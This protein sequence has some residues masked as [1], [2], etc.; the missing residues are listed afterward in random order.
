[1]SPSTLPNFESEARRL[2]YQAIGGACREYRIQHL[3]VAHHEDDQAETVL[4]RLVNGHKGMGLQGMKA[5]AEIP[6]CWGM[7][8]VSQSRA[9]NI[10]AKQKTGQRHMDSN[11]VENDYRLVGLESGGLT[12]HRPL[13]SFPK[14]RLKMT[15]RA[16][17]IQWVE[18]ETNHD[19][20]ITPRNAIRHLLASDRLPLALQKPSLLALAKTTQEKL[21]E[22][23]ARANS[24]FLNCDIIRF[25]LR[26]G[27]LLVRVPLG[28]ISTKHVPDKYRN[29][30]LIRCQYNAGLLLRKLT[31]LVSPRDIVSLQKLESVAKAIFPDLKDPCD[32]NGGSA[33][34][35]ANSSLPAS[36]TACGVQFRRLESTGAET[37]HTWSRLDP[38]YI[39]ELTRQPYPASI[40]L[41]TIYIPPTSLSPTH[42]APFHL[43]DGRYWIRVPNPTPNTHTLLI[44]PF[45]PSDLQPFQLSLPPARRT[46]LTNLLKMSAPG[47]V[48]WTLPAI[49]ILEEG[50]GLIEGRGRVIALPTLGLVAEG[51][52]GHVSWEI[53]YKNVDLREGREA[54]IVR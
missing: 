10:M 21:K 22:R 53:R 35:Q 17:G 12:V 32:Q 28:T 51:W 11:I 18:D 25:D 43:W 42:Q 54:A 52:E 9:E 5:T 1:M 8:G 48:R 41:P 38:K 45:Q 44:R 26:S 37:P 27:R 34:V 33:T 31:E 16:M 7:H 24:L 40:N 23:E 46:D 20:T 13:L 3:L 50:D 39:W 47:K 2:R 30:H 15:C 19:P 49:A 29:K 4:L 6:E 14:G 36:L